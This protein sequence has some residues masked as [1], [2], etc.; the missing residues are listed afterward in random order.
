MKD[1]VIVDIDGTIA[2][3]GDRLK[4]LEQVPKDWDSFYANCDEDEPIEEIC[5]LIDDLDSMDYE[6]VFCTGRR[7]LEREKT[8]SWIKKNIYP[9]SP[10][11]I[12]RRLLMRATGDFRHDTI[13]KPELLQ[14]AGIA[15][16]SIA[17]ILEDRNSMVKHWRSLGIIC[18]QVAEGD[19]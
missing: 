13:V 4:Y 2:K 17:F 8:I 1:I 7:E 18:L 5:K 3:V 16:D 14:A 6:L 15:L 9:Y 11:W 19:F 10:K 12:S